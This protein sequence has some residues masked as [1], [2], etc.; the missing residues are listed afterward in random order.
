M[1]A[2]IR[3]DGHIPWVTLGEIDEAGLHAALTTWLGAP[4]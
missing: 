2:L 4:A 3:P 1:A